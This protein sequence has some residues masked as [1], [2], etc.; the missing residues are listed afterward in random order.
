MSIATQNVTDI[1]ASYLGGIIKQGEVDDIVLEIRSPEYF[2]DE[3]HQLIYSAI[4]DLYQADKSIEIQILANHLLKKGKLEDVGG[5]T[6]L[7]EITENAAFNL[8]DYTAIIKNAYQ[9]RKISKTFTDI[10]TRAQLPGAEAR[11][12]ISKAEECLL[13]LDNASGPDYTPMS[14]IAVN[15]VNEICAEEKK[16]RYYIRTRVDDLNTEIIGFFRGDMI[17]IAAPPSMGKTSF[18]L[19][20]C[21]YNAN[22]GRTSL[23]ISLDQTRQS[24]VQRQITSLTGISKA[25]MFSGNLSERQK[26]NLAQKA[27]ELA[28]ADKL[29]ISDSA[30]LNVLD[31]RTMARRVKRTKGLDI[32]VIDYVQQIRPHR[33][34]ESRNLELTEI[35]GILKSIAKELDIP[36]LVLSQLN[37]EYTNLPINPEKNQ[38]GFP[39]VTMLRESGALEQDA[40]MIIFPHVPYEVMKKKYGTQSETFRDWLRDNPDG[41]KLAYMVVGK[42]KDGWTGTVEC[43]RDIVKMRFYSETERKEL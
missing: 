30:V 7:V 1:E 4:L 33:R 38:W 22:W 27:A 18:A 16:E 3:K 40:N 39:S 2:F 20:T 21:M 41:D 43:C 10:A 24:I 31:I 34:F 14:D 25:E 11:G 17:I 36:V 19:D 9:A 13:N 15:F 26:D 32:L 28:T 29:L 42:N 6:Y 37:R 35:S 23:F 8:D 5:R 12:L